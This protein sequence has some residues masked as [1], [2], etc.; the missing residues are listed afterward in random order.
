MPLV[1]AERLGAG[2]Q[3]T[4]LLLGD[5]QAAQPGIAAE[6]GDDQVGALGQQP[7]H[8]PG[9]HGDPVQQR[10]RQQ[11]QR[12]RALQRDPLGRELA[13][14][15]AEEREADGHH[16]ERDRARPG[17]RQVILPGQPGLEETGQGLGPVR[18][19]EQGGQGHA[20]LHGGEEPVRVLGQAR[21]SLAPPPA[22]GQRP[23]LAFAQR[24]EGHLGAREEP[25]DE[26]D[27]EDDNDV[28]HDL[29]I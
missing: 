25:P 23:D 13:Q 24:D 18:A 1:L 14:D 19:G 26:D 27:D 11:R 8:R 12:G 2:H 7:D 3:V 6:Q 20:D 5:G 15:Q 9:Q 22:L 21:R 10:R 16:D 28:Q 29:L 4:Q 17:R